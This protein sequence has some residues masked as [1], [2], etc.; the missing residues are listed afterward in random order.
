MDIIKTTI[1]VCSCHS[2]ID[3]L[4]FNFD[5]NLFAS[6]QHKGEAIPAK[7]WC[8]T[9]CLDPVHSVMYL[10][11]GRGGGGQ[12]YKER[13]SFNDLWEFNLVKHVW[14]KTM[15]QNT[16]PSRN[17]HSC[18]YYNH[19]LYIYGGIEDLQR[20][21]DLWRYSIS[22]KSWHP[23]EMWGNLPKSIY[24]HTC[25]VRDSRIFISGGSCGSGDYQNTMYSIDLT[26]GL[27]LVREITPTFSRR[28]HTWIR[29]F[30]NLCDG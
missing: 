22:S 12:K 14:T 21:N 2:N 26:T 3:V 5:T 11:G 28:N 18:I 20:R 23:V 15:S 16:I 6:V 24:A 17:S 27:S 30:M 19:D 8:H 4:E 7:R 29:Y 1:I 25:C 13:P 9:A 10:F